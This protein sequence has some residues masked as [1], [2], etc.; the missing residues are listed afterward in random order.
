[1]PT[2]S[3]V[4]ITPRSGVTTIDALL[5]TGPD[6]NYFA[7]NG[8]TTPLTNTL[9][10][11]FSTASGNEPGETGQ[12]A[13]SLTQQSFTRGAFAYISQL[14]GI[15][16]V[17]TAVGT[18]AQIHL[19]NTDI[20][21]GANVTGLCSW[22]SS[23]T[24]L[25]SELKS[26]DADAWVYLDNVE[27]RGQNSNLTP[28]G[29]GYETLLHELGHALGLKHPFE[30]AGDNTTHLSTMQ[31]T[32]LNTLMSYTDLGGPY[33]QYRAYDVAALNW[34]YGGDG[35]GGAAGLN[36]S[37]ADMVGTAGND[38]LRPGLG[39][40]VVDG[41]GGV[42][43]AAYAGSR[44]NYTVSKE[45]T[46]FSVTDR[47]G[48]N[49]HDTL[50][51]VERLQFDDGWKALDIDGT[52]GQLFRL[53]QATFN[54]PADQAGIGYWL[55]AAETTGQSQVTIANEFMKQQEYTKLYGTN[56]TD[57]Q[58]IELVYA[59]ALHRAPD[60]AGNKYWNDMMQINHISRA[61]VLLFFSESQENQ[62]QVIGQIK[63]GIDFQLWKG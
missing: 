36:A 11:T 7:P 8:Y 22:Q 12:T 20:K 4:T 61:D 2:V 15:K 5:D 23:Y 40:N 41:L 51:N 44:A 6:W 29:N 26:Y 32:T 52:A 30:D 58:F 45:T 62:A 54:R 1:M 21:T 43:T 53:Y 63:D 47:V 25:G 3:D 55:W 56:P 13:F 57:A 16:F 35:L 46:G 49:G 42:D 14:T 31:D 28:G 39:N 9:Y 50:V 60:V 27:W 48:T 59:N 38:L 18:D 19:C 33:S 34:L 17:E 37:T 10:Y 24:Y